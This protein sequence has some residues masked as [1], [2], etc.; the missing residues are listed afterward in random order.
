M[1][2]PRLAN[3]DV[4]FIVN[5]I[6]LGAATRVGGPTGHGRAQNRPYKKKTNTKC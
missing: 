3:V 6:L 1:Q 5:C 4:E 2:Y